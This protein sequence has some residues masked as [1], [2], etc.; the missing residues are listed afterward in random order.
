[1]QFGHA[2]SWEIRRASWDYYYY[3]YY[4]WTNY[5]IFIIRFL[6]LLLFIK[7]LSNKQET[8]RKANSNTKPLSP[9]LKPMVRSTLDKTWI[10]LKTCLLENIFFLH[11]VCRQ[12]APN[13][14]KLRGVLEIVVGFFFLKFV[15]LLKWSSDS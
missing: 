12:N 13:C 6:F 3:Y 4:Y 5:M 9:V 2:S 8:S 10:L 15:I 14:S 7:T 1:M 11:F